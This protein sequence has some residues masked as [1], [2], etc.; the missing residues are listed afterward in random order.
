MT[1]VSIVTIVST[2]SA[3]SIVGTYIQ[4][5]GTCHGTTFD[6]KL[7]ENIMAHWPLWRLCTVTSDIDND[8]GVY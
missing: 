1:I 6:D 7:C 4:S 8:K 2:V 3:V 5:H